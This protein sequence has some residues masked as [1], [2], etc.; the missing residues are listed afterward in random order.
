M[1]WETAFLE[2]RLQS[3]SPLELVAILYEY[4]VLRVTEARTALAAGD[5]AGRTTAISKAMAIVGELQGSLNFEAGGE[6]A[7]NLARLYDYIQQ[8]LLHGNVNQ[9]DAALAESER[10]LRTV[11]AAWEKVAAG[12][13]ADSGFIAGAQA[14][15]AVRGYI[16]GSGWNG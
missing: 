7:G 14:A 8:R 1:A 4:A 11:G 12:Q 9:E 13:V 15:A 3:A 6:V 5:V 2:S 10:L 16:A